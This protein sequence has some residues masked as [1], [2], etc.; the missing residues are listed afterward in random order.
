MKR[1]FQV[2]KILKFRWKSS[3]WHENARAFF[4]E[5]LLHSLPFSYQAERISAVFLKRHSEVAN[6]KEQKNLNISAFKSVQFNM[7]SSLMVSTQ[8]KHLHQLKSSF[9]TKWDQR[10]N[11]T[12]IH[13]QIQSA[14]STAPFDPPNSSNLRSPCPTLWDL[15]R[16]QKN[17]HLEIRR[18]ISHLGKSNI[19]I[20]NA[21]SWRRYLSFEKGKLLIQMGVL[22][23]KT[24]WE[25]WCSHFSIEVRP[26]ASSKTNAECSSQTSHG[27]INGFLVLP[28]QPSTW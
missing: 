12:L 9:P 5:C 28:K 14:I 27:G 3:W 10:S 17:W 13:T 7:I 11:S 21:P 26:V 22:R 18:N 4:S 15:A 16:G 23:L 20:N 8:L 19:I 25:H 1:T 2:W 6:F 24:L